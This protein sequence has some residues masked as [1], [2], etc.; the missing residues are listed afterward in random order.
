MQ[1]K[2]KIICPL[3][4][5]ENKEDSNFCVKCGFSLKDDDIPTMVSNQQFFSQGAI[6]DGRYEIIR[7]IGEGGMG[8]VFYAKDKKL[9][10][11]V[12]IKALSFSL[13]KDKEF[14]DR[15]LREAIT[16][17]QIDHPNICSVYDVVIKKEYSYIVM[18]YV[19]GENLASILKKG[20]LPIEKAIDIGIQLAE[21]LNAAHKKGIVHRDIKPSNIVISKNGYVK[22]LDFGLAK[23]YLKEENK[24]DSSI[25]KYEI[26]KTGI[27]V[28]TVSYMSPEQAE[29][30]KVDHRSDI[31][32]LG[33]ILYEM[34][35]GKKPFEGRSHISVMANIINAEVIP[36]SN[37]AKNVPAG[38]DEIIIKALMKNP[39]ERY[40]SGE[41]I[42]N[43]LLKIKDGEKI[44]I[45][46]TQSKKKTGVKKIMVSIII[47]AIVLLLGF[48][49]VFIL[50]RKKPMIVVLNAKVDNNLSKIVGEEVSFLL[51]KSL[52]QFENYEIMN[53]NSF[54]D[55]KKKWGN[56]KK[57][58]KKE[59]VLLF[60]KPTI[61]KIGE[62]INIDTHLIFSDK[63]KI[64]TINGV[65]KK[66]ILDYQIDN[67]VER[68][69]GS[70][71]KKEKIRVKKI[72]EILT[73]DWQAFVNFFHGYKF[74]KK[75]YIS[76]AE[77]FFKKGLETDDKLALAYYYLTEISIFNGDYIS[78]KKYIDLANKNSKKLINYD[79]YKIFAM[80]E[81]L[82]LNFD[83]QR[84]YLKK[85]IK[86]KPRDKLSYYSLA[87]SYFHRGEAKKALKY[88]AKVLYIDAEF[89]PA[90][91]HAGFCF[92][93]IG[94]HL[95]ALDYL[96][97]YKELNGGANAYDSL[98]DG[99]FYLGDY[100]NAQNN[101]LTA[102]NMDPNLDWIY[103]SLGYI[104][105]MEHKFEKAIS[106]N[107]EYAERSK[108]NRYKALA[109]VQLSFF[110]YYVGN[111]KEAEQY[112]KDAEKIY[113]IKEINSFTPEIYYFKGLI[114]LKAGNMKKA[115]D[116]LLIFEN[117]IKKYNISKH[118]FFP[119]LKFYLSLKA[120]IQFEK[121]D[122]KAAFNSMEG[123]L[124]MKEKLG[125][126]STFYNYPYF[127][128]DYLELLRK[129][130]KEK[131][132]RYW[133]K[134]I[135]EYNPYFW[136]KFNNINTDID[137]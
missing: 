20:K 129:K 18:Q 1:E 101:K 19:E 26:T 136:E 104:Y 60:I 95:K 64:L 115:E 131:K 44:S 114:N 127:I 62:M 54:D 11:D 34:F 78:A 73:S 56:K 113:S 92:S 12:A 23:P 117:I 68:L 47:A 25:D 66:S 28:G 67:I 39:S 65:G 53:Q 46:R 90:L 99:Y 106:V 98:G 118:K 123:L 7:T 59:R 41:D 5:T 10:K 22:I 80:E 40:Q 94:D 42:K 45:N 13:I 15:L 124:S 48:L 89:S 2:K 63:D 126:W 17:G 103:Y 109:M 9:K 83:K 108:I 38:V 69:N 137:K 14:K 21:G 88:Y 50:N 70:L 57:A 87:E 27:I 133:L 37:I 30:E 125:Y 74:W 86:I 75:L 112:I 52:S 32:S 31:F 33:I 85:I 134:I 79:K 122:L 3:C 135:N 121:G 55:L 105:F 111:I 49:S 29:G 102:L 96:E 82:S 110:N 72:S 128:N 6:L 81:N 91:N 93:Y 51:E 120:H 130:N 35:T 77:E 116:S 100:L 4:G 8:V 84:E 61:K 119:L 43:E 71:N 58:V 132:F 76:Q 36:P 107:K 24:K 97:K 16:L